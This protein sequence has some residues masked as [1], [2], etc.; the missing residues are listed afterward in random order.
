[1][2]GFGDRNGMGKAVLNFA[3]TNDF[4]MSYFLWIYKMRE[5]YL[6]AFKSEIIYS[7][8]VLYD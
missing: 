5:K 7:N 8:I 3:I 1:M 2:R 4:G 6:I